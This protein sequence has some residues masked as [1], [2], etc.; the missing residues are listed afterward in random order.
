MTKFICLQSG[1]EGRTTGATGAPG[2]IEL[3][4]RVRNRLSQLL[5]E[6]GFMVQLVGADPPKAE[7]Y[8]DFDLFLALHGDADIYGTGGGVVACIAPPPYDSSE[9]SNAESRRIR[10][11]IASIYFKETGI[12]N[13]PER[14]NKNMTEYYMWPKLTPKTPCVI[15]EMGVVQDAHDKVLLGNTE[16]IASALARSLCKAFDVPYDLTTPTPPTPS[17]LD[18]LKEINLNLTKEIEGLKVSQGELEVRITDLEQKLALSQKSEADYQKS[19]KSANSENQRIS[20]EVAY[21]KPYKLFTRQ[22][23]KRQ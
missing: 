3:N 15:I 17:E 10:D 4:V 21:Y 1:H 7:Y 23:S 8:K 22:P 11:T 20:A 2:E 19:L 18:L 13:H 14:S 16:L 5:I 6:R 9:E 12:V